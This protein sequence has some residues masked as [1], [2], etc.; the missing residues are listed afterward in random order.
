MPIKDPEKK[1][2]AQK[3][4]DEKRAGRTR[5]F[6]TVV[7]PT[8]E[9]LEKLGSDY[10]GSAGYGSLPDDWLDRLEELHVAALISPLH[11]KDRNPDGK[12][13]KPHYHVMLI[14]EG[15]KDFE[16][17][18][19]PIFDEIGGVGR[20]MVNSARG[21]A[22]YLCHLDNPEKTQY[23]PAEVRCMGGADYYGITNLPTDDIK[24]LGEIMA[25][26][27][28]QEIYSFAEFLEVCQL[29]R[30]DWYSLA[31]LSRGWIIREYIK[32]LA[33]EK[34][35]GY[36]R[37]SDRVPATDPATGEVAGE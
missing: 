21:Y 15:P 22:R 9:Q 20:E 32:S 17:Q 33:W 29:L 31:A 27:R 1:K 4:A 11:D 13:K 23:D 8:K 25:Y 34:E 19:K 5:N 37:V 16:T 18:V 24:M 28:E 10:D 12:I 36:V 26:I 35:T 14:F 2:A 7:Y 6:A 30:P 3:R